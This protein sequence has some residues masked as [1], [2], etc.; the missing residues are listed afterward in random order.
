MQLVRRGAGRRIQHAREVRKTVTIVFCDLVGSTALGERT[1]PELLRE[2]MSSYHATLR[3]ILERHGGTVEKFVGDAAMAVF[4]IPNVHEDDAVRAVR[5]AAE[6]RHAVAGLGLSVRIGVGTGE[7]AAGTGE[8]LVTG[9][10]VNVAARWGA[11][12]PGRS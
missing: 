2:L 11:P 5:A 10:A 7:V 1:D 9:D 4:G 3:S 12:G 8:T 6:M